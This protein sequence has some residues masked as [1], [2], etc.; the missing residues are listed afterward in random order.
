MERQLLGVGWC[1]APGSW[2]CIV[3]SSGTVR[4]PTL[5]LHGRHE[6]AM[7]IFAADEHKI[8]QHLQLLVFT[9]SVPAS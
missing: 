7:P 2:E 8:I 3:M 4:P 9:V 1:V 6:L 5:T